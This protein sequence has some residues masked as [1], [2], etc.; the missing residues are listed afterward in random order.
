MGSIDRQN[1]WSLNR[2][3]ENNRGT[4]GNEGPGVCHEAR[5]LVEPLLQIF[6]PGSIV[7]SEPG[8]V[9]EVNDRNSALR[10]RRDLTGARAVVWHGGCRHAHLTD[11][12]PTWRHL[13]TWNK[14]VYM[15]CRET[16]I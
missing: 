6:L 1:V 9:F 5:M 14:N 16:C 11:T 7:S 4:H 3:E 10:V 12:S 13:K 8:A 2:R 15:H